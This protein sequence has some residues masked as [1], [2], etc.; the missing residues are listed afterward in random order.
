MRSDL[1]RHCA[2]QTVTSDLPAEY[3]FFHTMENSRFLHCKP[4]SL[5][6]P[7]SIS[8]IPTMWSRIALLVCL[9]L[10]VFHTVHAGEIFRMRRAASELIISGIESCS[11][12]TTILRSPADVEAIATCTTFTGTIVMAT[13]V[14]P[15][16]DLP[17]VETIVGSIVVA[18][19]TGVTTITGDKLATVTDQVV[20][21]SL[22]LLTNITLPFW[23]SVGTMILRRIP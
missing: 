11:N 6:C 9:N 1:Q 5:S 21:D 23:S 7:V 22:P 4:L 3:L 17:G 2:E 20:L 12:A 16:A 10:H 18:N 8:G 13:D 19:N 14:A 15:T